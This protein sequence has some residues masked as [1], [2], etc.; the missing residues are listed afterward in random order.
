[1]LKKIGSSLDRKGWMLV[2]TSELEGIAARF[3]FAM[4]EN[5]ETLRL[6][7]LLIPS[8]K[9]LSSGF[10]SVRSELICYVLL[11]NKV[12]GDLSSLS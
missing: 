4:L 3:D 8:F 7:R 9:C 11:F 5:P 2:G 10:D 1:L 6:S 12:V